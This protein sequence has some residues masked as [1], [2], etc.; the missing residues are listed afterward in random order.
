MSV[1]DP[2]LA[3]H[4]T[5]EDTT[6]GLTKEYLVVFYWGDNTVE[7]LDA[8][9]GKPFLK[10]SPCANLTKAHFF[11]GAQ[12]VVFGRVLTLVRYADKVTEQLSEKVS[13]S[14]IVVVG[15]QGF[16]RI[17]DCL[18]IA[19][20]ECGF[21]ICDMQVIELRSADWDTPAAA[22]ASSLSG[23]ASSAAPTVGA[24]AVLPRSF[25][26]KKVIVLNLIRDQA[27]AKAQCLPER[28]NVGSG[29]W[30]ARDKAE[31]EA[32]SAL[33]S[34]A[35]R[36]PAAEF[37]CPSS[38][39]LVKP[40][41]IV[42]GRGGEAVQYLLQA[43]REGGLELV[44]ISQVTFSSAQADAFLQPYKGVL[45]EYKATVEHVASGACWALQFVARD[46]STDPVE[47]VRAAVGPFDPT[48]AKTLYPKSLRARLGKDAA[49]NG[50][51]CTDL[52]E[53]GPEDAAFVWGH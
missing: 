9:T 42:G 8:K 31:V 16:S 2:R 34:L 33:I 5:Y 19:T 6:A 23:S 51:H 40:H 45:N 36:R 14:V 21:G 10:R 44:A 29:I 22:S 15:P 28:F 50:V 53:D 27:I 4:A 48:I 41:V 12:V 17:G 30:V 47:V 1:T 13:E 37:G 3:F 35:R 38:V 49:R 46:E 39:V 25:S 18:D 32:A 20:I 26:N 11:L 43:C 24:A 52:P 7:L